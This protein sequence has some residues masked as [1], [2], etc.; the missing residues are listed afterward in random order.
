MLSIVKTITGGKFFHSSF[1][2]E[3]SATPSSTT[4][5]ALNPSRSSSIDGE[6]EVPHMVFPLAYYADKIVVSMPGEPL[7]ELGKV[8]CMCRMYVY[9]AC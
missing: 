3:S 7:P 1:G 6:A 8:G 9:Y 2:S 5:G 4:H